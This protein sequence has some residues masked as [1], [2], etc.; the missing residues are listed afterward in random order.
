[1]ETSPYRR[2]PF[3]VQAVEITDENIDEIGTLIGRVMV[4][5]SD[6]QKFIQVDHVLVPGV[7][8]VY[9]GF[10][11]TVMNDRYRCYSSKIFKAQFE[12]DGSAPTVDPAQQSLP[13]LSDA[14]L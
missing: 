4:R 2:K 5:E 9:T 12:P 3:R 14:D 10:W 6:G 7:D 1:M 11:L 8:R 13:F